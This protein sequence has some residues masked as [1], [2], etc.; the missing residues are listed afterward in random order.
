MKKKTK[1]KLNSSLFSLAFLIS[2]L[3][4]IAGATGNGYLFYNSFFETLS[5]LNEDP[6]ATISFK[7]NTAQRKF[8][9]RTIWDR[10]RNNSPLYNGDT[11][12][13]SVNA[14]ATVT[15]NDGNRVVLS[16]NTML[17]IYLNEDKTSSLMMEN[18]IKMSLKLQLIVANTQ[19]IQTIYH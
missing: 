16:E 6:I 15:F 12:H 2:I 5:K 13:T 3:I 9:D 14:E 7:Y 1:S 8:S 11:I 19:C 4:C 10:L 17:Q 18:A